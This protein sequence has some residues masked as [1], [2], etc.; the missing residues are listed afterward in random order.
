MVWMHIRDGLHGMVP[1]DRVADLEQTRLS[2][3]SEAA[4]HKKVVERK[5]AAV[6]PA[7]L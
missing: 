5:N 7:Q 2:E 4:G 1:T 3:S 6:S